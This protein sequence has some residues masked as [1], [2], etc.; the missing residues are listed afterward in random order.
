MADLAELTGAGRLEIFEGYHLSP[1][2]LLDVGECEKE[3]EARHI[4]FAR[5]AAQGQHPDAAEKILNQA[6]ERV[7]GGHFSY[8]GK[9]FDAEAVKLQHLPLW[10]Y[11]ELRHRHP[12]IT[13][14]KAGQLLKDHPDPALVQDVV[15]GLAGYTYVKKNPTTPT[16]EP[17][18][19]PTGTPS[20]PPSESSDSVTAI[21]GD[22]PSPSSNTP[23]DCV[24][25]AATPPPHAD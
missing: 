21:S 4:A 19:T 10:V 17:A 15:L 1:P 12:D 11:V 23:S 25:D 22:S 8:G 16:N 18:E 14:A 7:T 3:F 5:V 9:P 20:S 6:M 13:R 24:T 2:D